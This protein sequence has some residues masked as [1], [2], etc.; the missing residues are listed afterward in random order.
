MNI[1]DVRKVE[2]QLS[3]VEV[4]NETLL[5]ITDLCKSVACDS[6]RNIGSGNRG[7]DLFE[8][9]GPPPL[10]VRRAVPEPEL[11]VARWPGP[12]VERT[13]GCLRRHR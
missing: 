10:E 7:E 1:E 8:Q 11:S 2:T 3:M 5:S 4:C 6:S 9:H 12:A 13:Q